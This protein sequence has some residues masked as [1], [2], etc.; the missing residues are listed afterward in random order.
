M[1]AVRRQG[2]FF[3]SG[4][5]LGLLRFPEWRRRFRGRNSNALEWETATFSIRL[6]LVFGKR[7]WRQ[8][9]PLAPFRAGA[10]PTSGPGTQLEGSWAPAGRSYR[11]SQAPVASSNGLP[12]RCPFGAELARLQDPLGSYS[13]SVCDSSLWA[14][15]HFLLTQGRAFSPCSETSCTSSSG[16]WVF[17]LSTFVYGNNLLVGQISSPVR[18]LR[19]TVPVL[20]TDT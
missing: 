16:F 2:Q 1:A 20:L 6:R 14:A 17:I 19:L 12:V 11:Y 3:P 4:R 8:W 5:T 7:L 13:L 10:E 15:C 18:D 9:Q